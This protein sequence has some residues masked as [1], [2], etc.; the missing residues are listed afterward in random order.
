LCAHHGVKWSYSGRLY[1]LTDSDDRFSTGIDALV[2][3]READLTRARIL[4]DVEERAIA[5]IPHGQLHDGYRIEYDPNTGKPLRRVLDPERAPLVREIAARLLAG[6]SAYTI[7]RDFN[8]RGLTTAKGK[9]WRG[10]NITKRIQSPTIAGL[11]VHRGKVLDDVQT[12]WPAIITP[13]EYAR[14]ITLLS[15][16][17]RKTNREG[18]HVKWL[19]TGVYRCGVCGAP[20]RMISGYRPNGTAVPLWPTAAKALGIGRTKAHQLVRT[21]ER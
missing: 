2:S 9:P 8:A 19:G 4:R 14:L 5:G 1:D 17:R 6:D 7:A 3:E 12:Q 20:V 11:R 18:S 15:D 10:Q 13:E 16:P 21:G